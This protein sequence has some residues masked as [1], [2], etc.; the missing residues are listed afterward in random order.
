MREIEELNFG[1]REKKNIKLGF[2]LRERLEK[3]NNV[4]LGFKFPRFSLYFL[5]YFIVARVFRIIS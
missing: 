3:M 2:F 4:F 1:F 5:I